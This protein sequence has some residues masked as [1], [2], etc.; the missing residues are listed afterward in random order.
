MGGSKKMLKLSRRGMVLAAAGL[1]LIAVPMIENPSQASNQEERI[2]EVRH[3]DEEWMKILGE[4]RFY[5]L[6]R[7]GTEIPTTSPLNNEKRKGTFVCAGCETPLFNSG[8]KYES[9]SGWPSFY[10]PLPGAVDETSDRSIGFFPRTEVRCH[11]CQGH[12]GHVFTDGPKPTGLRYCMNGLAL[13]FQPA[14]ESV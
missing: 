5:V 14:A 1:A 2:G 9:G 10:Q 13:Q 3:T 11:R 7:A 6:R 8:T 12:L 4:S